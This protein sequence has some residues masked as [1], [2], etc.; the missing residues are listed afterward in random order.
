MLIMISMTKRMNTEKLQ[1]TRNM[2]I[3]RAVDNVSA[4]IYEG[5]KTTRII[6]TYDADI[7]CF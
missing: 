1:N 7:I 4:V 3:M 6:Y 5:K 2:Y